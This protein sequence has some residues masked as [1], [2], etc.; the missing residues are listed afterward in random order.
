MLFCDVKTI[1]LYEWET[2][3]SYFELNKTISNSGSLKF[4]TIDQGLLKILRILC[5]AVAL[6]ARVPEN[7][8]NF[9]QWIPEPINLRKKGLKFTFFSVQNKQEI[10]FESLGP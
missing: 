10:K 9:G 7:S 5:I 1:R 4:S 6:S 2:L 8:T 3:K